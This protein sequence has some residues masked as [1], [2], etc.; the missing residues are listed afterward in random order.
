M[1]FRCHCLSP[2]RVGR[3][4]TITSFVASRPPRRVTTTNCGETPSATLRSLGSGHSSKSRETR[5]ARQLPR[6]ISLARCRLQRQVRSAAAA[7]LYQARA[8]LSKQMPRGWATGRTVYELRRKSTTNSHAKSPM[9]QPGTTSLC[10]ACLK[11]RCI[12]EI[13]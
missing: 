3:A 10:S 12:S 8:V 2:A 1:M 11:V 7:V 6:E 5:A 4:Q 13:V 9:L